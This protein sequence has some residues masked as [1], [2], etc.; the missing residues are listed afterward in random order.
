MQ[1]KFF[2]PLGLVVIVIGVAVA[3]GFL[4]SPPTPEPTVTIANFTECAAA[5]YPIMESYP[6][7]CRASNGQV[8]QEDI[9]NILDKSD[10]IRVTTLAPNDVVKS[11]LTVAGEARGN[12]YFEASFPVILKDGQGNEVTKG[13]AQAQS[14]WMTTNFVPF[15]VTLTFTPPVSTTGTLVL[16]KDNPSGLPQNDDEL[17]IP[18]QF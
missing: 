8:F 12:W 10:L 1:Q 4:G 9:G 14:D 18:I 17:I 7:Q 16:K 15:T 13:I 6:R 5:G 11:P 2:L 3:M